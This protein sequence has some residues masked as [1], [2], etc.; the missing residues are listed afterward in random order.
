MDYFFLANQKRSRKDKIKDS[1]F[2][3]DALNRDVDLRKQA[4]IYYQEWCQAK[5]DGKE[6][7]RHG[8]FTLYNY[9]W[10]LNAYKKAELFRAI[11]SA[12]RYDNIGHALL[13]N[14][15]GGNPNGGIDSILQ[16]VHFCIK[17][18]RSQLLHDSLDSLTTREVTAGQ[19]RKPLRV[20]FEGEP[21]IDEGGVKKEYF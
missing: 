3:N 20:V 17:I 18:R 12:D 19:I 11:A 15:F 2:Y 10:T 5:K 16:Q 13:N 14:L 7:D 21:A 6:F 1:E 4:Q 8:F 9:P